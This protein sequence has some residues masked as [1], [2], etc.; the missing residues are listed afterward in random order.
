M[1]RTLLL[2]FI[3]A[4]GSAIAATADERQSVGLALGSGGAGGLAH[5]AMLEVFEELSIRPDAISGTSIGAIVGALYAAGLDSQEIR[6]LFIEF[7]ESAMNPFAGLLDGGDGV[8]WTDLLDFDF[9]NGGLISADGFLELV[10]QHIEARDFADLD[11]PLQIVAT[12]Y[13]SGEAV[14]FDEGD[15]MRAIKASMAVPGLFAPVKDGDRLLIDGGVANPLP[16]DLLAGQD[17]IVAIDVT[18][19]R[20]P[21]P[22]GPPGLTMLLFKSFE[23]MQQSLIRE[24]YAAAPPDIYIKPELDDVRL[25][26]FDRVDE[27]ISKADRAADELRGRLEHVMS[28]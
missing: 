5:I 17:L 6:A 13:W 7:G 27:V 26:H 16:W 9:A 18:G 15:L 8:G 22:D 20:A 21:S 25:L 24:K 12:D 10:G 4:G 14:V 2:I 28:K 23:I 1:L 19:I 11:I 3:L